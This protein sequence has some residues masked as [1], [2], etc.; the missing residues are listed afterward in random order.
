MSPHYRSSS[1]IDNLETLICSSLRYD[2]MQVFVSAP[3]S[4]A[5]NKLCPRPKHARPSETVSRS[6]CSLS[7]RLSLRAVIDVTTGFSLPR[8]AAELPPWIGSRH[9]HWS[10][11]N[12]GVLPIYD[13]K[14]EKLAA[15]ELNMKSLGDDC[16]GIFF[17][18]NDCKLPL[19]ELLNI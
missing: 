12:F 1:L 5:V 18:K 10:E 6:V 19:Q 4:A 17:G 16:D 11:I 3:C 7:S 14:I 2:A 15:L 13:H 9:D 8:F